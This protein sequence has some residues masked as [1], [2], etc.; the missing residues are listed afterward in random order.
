MSRR[1]WKKKPLKQAEL[2]EIVKAIAPEW[3]WP[4][5]GVRVRTTDALEKWA[6][7]VA[8]RTPLCDPRREE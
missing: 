1:R 7:D 6:E 3:V 2:A 8:R 5:S 4:A